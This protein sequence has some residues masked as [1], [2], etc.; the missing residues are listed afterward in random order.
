MQG[1]KGNAENKEAL[2]EFETHQCGCGY[3]ATTY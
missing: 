2:D 3:Y 1:L